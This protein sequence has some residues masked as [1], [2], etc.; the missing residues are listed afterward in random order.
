MGLGLGAAL[1]ATHIIFDRSRGQAAAPPPLDRALRP[2]SGPRLPVAGFSRWHPAQTS[3]HL[4][5]GSAAS[6]SMDD[7]TYPGHA[8]KA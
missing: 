6:R 2:G 5:V 4:A 8:T 7:L 1:V 3:I